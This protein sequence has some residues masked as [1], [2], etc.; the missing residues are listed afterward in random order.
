MQ[1]L[2]VDIKDQYKS[3][4]GINCSEFYSGFRL[5]QMATSFIIQSGVI[6]TFKMLSAFF[7]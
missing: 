4:L 7:V 6:A 5:T 1:W 2:N 3:G